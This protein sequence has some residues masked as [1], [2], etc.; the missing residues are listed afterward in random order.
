MYKSLSPSRVDCSTGA[1]NVEECVVEEVVDEVVE[2]VVEVDARGGSA[3]GFV[4]R[5][6]EGAVEE[7]VKRG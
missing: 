7:R 5:K 2:E 3:G 4:W 6:A 1:E